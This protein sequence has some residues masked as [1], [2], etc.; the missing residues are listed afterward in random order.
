LL[1]TKDEK[2]QTASKERKDEYLCIRRAF[3]V[4]H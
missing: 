4:A 1:T 2:R 3:E